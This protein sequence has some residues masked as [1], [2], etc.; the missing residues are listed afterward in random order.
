MS[1][2]QSPYAT[3]LATWLVGFGLLFVVW[4]VVYPL[5]DTGFPRGWGTTSGRMT[6]LHRR[7]KAEFASGR[8]HQ[9][10]EALL[11][12][13]PKDSVAELTRDGWGT[14]FRL[15]VSGERFRIL[16][17]GVNRQ[18]GDADDVVVTSEME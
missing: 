16:S 4:V 14:P 2:S 11:A 1:L 9:T 7:L 3:R 6:R 10:L 12:S 13:A 8:Q 18:F 5:M 15:E 17:A